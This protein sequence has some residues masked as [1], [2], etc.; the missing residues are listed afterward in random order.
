MF[1]DKFRALQFHTCLKT[2]NLTWA[3][4]WDKKLSVELHPCETMPRLERTRGRFRLRMSFPSRVSEPP[5][6][7]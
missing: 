3:R 1:W 4:F 7:S 2:H 6:R 5:S